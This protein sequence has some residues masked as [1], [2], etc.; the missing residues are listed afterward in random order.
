MAADVPKAIY[1]IRHAESCANLL[2]NKIVDKYDDVKKTHNIP[3][4]LQSMLI[5][6]GILMMLVM[7]NRVIIVIPIILVVS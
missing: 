1:W 3:T 7:L 4:Y 6:L 5:N 2:E